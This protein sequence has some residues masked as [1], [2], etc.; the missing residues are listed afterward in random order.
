MS[1][2][3]CVNSAELIVYVQVTLNVSARI[4]K[5]HLKGLWSAKNVYGVME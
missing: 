4:F 5:L 3:G 1:D 2:K